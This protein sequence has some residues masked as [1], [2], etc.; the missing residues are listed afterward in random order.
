[1]YGHL[2]GTRLSSDEVCRVS[3]PSTM[4][5]LRPRREWWKRVTKPSTK[6]AL[7][8]VAIPRSWAMLYGSKEEA[9]RRTDPSPENHTDHT[10]ARFSNQGAT[11]RQGST[12]VVVWR[13][14][15]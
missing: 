4:L 7:K 12:E 5:T 14:R 6:P 1:M 11:F 2:E 3:N 8:V 15:G 13:S 10:F 9:S